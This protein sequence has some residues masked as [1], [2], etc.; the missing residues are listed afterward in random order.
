MAFDPLDQKAPLSAK[1]KAKVE[2]IRASMMAIDRAMGRSIADIAQDFKVSPSTVKL[3]L[4]EAE[5]EGFVDH[6]RRM[7]YDRLGAKVLAVYEAHLDQGNLQAARD[8]AQGLGILRNSSPQTKEK[9]ITTLAEW[10]KDKE[11]EKDA[12]IN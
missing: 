1:K 7:A 9:S 8:L 11:E 6:Y 12:G 4:T 5:E 3:Y 2:G 10:R